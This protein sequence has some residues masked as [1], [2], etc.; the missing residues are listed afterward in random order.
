MHSLWNLL[1]GCRHEHYS[2]PQTGRSRER[3]RPAAAILTGHYVVCLDC[4]AELPYDMNAMKVVRS[5]RAQRLYL[6]PQ[7]SR[8]GLIRG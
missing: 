8:T 7:K 3:K 6:A 1:F 2:W 5:A 4:S